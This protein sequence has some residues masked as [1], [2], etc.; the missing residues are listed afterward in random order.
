[1]F[2]GHDRL[3]GSGCRSGMGGR[4]FVMLSLCRIVC[5]VAVSPCQ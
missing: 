5:V 1:M 2:V 3:M 4:C